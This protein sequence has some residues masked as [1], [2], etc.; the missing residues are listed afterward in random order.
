MPEGTGAVPDR[1][2]Y[3][4]K[5]ELVVPQ[6]GEKPLPPNDDHVEYTYSTYDSVILY[7]AP[8]SYS[9]LQTPSELFFRGEAQKKA[10]G[11]KHTYLAFTGPS[12]AVILRPSSSKSRFG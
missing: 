3:Q 5:Q 12:G 9:F 7:P 11:E 8:G 6:D 2:I 4:Q 10:G 1:C